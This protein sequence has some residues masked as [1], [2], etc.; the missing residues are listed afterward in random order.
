MALKA[1]LAQAQDSAREA[2]EMIRLHN[3]QEAA[4]K[5]EIREVSTFPDRVC[6]INLRFLQLERT[7]NRDGA[8]LEYLKN[9]V[10]KYMETQEH[11]KL[12]PVLTTLLQFSPEE[13][14]R[15]QGA[16]TAQQASGLWSYVRRSISSLRR[17]ADPL[18]QV[19]WGGAKSPK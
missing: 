2:E 15:V 11:E 7:K 6:R 17:E 8:N 19:G 10:L 4:L 9:I 13:V 1:G 18:L 14:A 12:L 16:R 3:L 5:K